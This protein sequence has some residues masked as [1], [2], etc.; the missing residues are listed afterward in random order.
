VVGAG[1]VVL[2]LLHHLVVAFEQLPAVHG[3]ASL[4]IIGPKPSIATA[5]SMVER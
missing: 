2:H 3:R 4:P 1:A 5:V